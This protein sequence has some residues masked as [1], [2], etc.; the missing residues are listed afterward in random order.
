MSAWKTI[1]YLSLEGRP[2]CPSPICVALVKKGYATRSVRYGYYPRRW[3]KHRIQR[4]LCKTC[5]HTFSLATGTS[6]F[7]QH[8]PFVNNPLFEWFASCGSQRR[9]ARIFRI[10]FKT[11]VR[12]FE[13]IGSESAL[14]NEEDRKKAA[15]VQDIQF[16]EMES[17]EHSKLKPLSIP[18]VVDSKTR[19]ILG[20]EVCKMPAKGHLVE[21]SLK[22][23][24]PREDQRE[25]A[26]D[27][28]F[29][30]LLK[31]ISPTAII[32]SDSKPQYAK[33]VKLHFPEA[34]YSQ[35]ISR[36]GRSSG[37]GELK[38]IGHDPIFSLNHT[39]AMI[40]ANV[41]RMFR[42]TWCTTKKLDRLIKHLE[43]YAKYHNTVLIKQKAPSSDLTSAIPSTA[44]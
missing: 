4:F 36:K 24:G 2:Q 31:N 18:L 9:A 14:F 29:R 35:V 22:K 11:V 34:H 20:F 32:L 19:K 44:A 23:Y 17:I 25:E 1:R 6:T 21:K 13:S 15:A 3:E 39:A 33:H 38:Q 43:I 16:D 10:N 26:L 7:R 27:R 5:N 41:N 37:L 40:R 28:L 30:R 8:K 42:K 12:K